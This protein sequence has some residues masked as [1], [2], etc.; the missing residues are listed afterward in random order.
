M[1]CRQKNTARGISLSDDMA[2]GRGGE[3]A[4]LAD[5]ELLHPIC[6][7]DLGYKLHDLWIVV[8]AISSNDQEASLDA[9]GYGKENAGDEGLAVVWLLKDLDL[10]P[11]S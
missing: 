4:I 7:T 1:T 9:F 10:F 8:P 5:Q 11:K 2:G 6:R 3:N